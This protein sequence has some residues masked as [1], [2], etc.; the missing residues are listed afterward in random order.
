MKN[1]EKKF[2]KKLTKKLKEIP[3]K[4]WE[5][6]QEMFKQVY[7]TNIENFSIVLGEFPNPNEKNYRIIIKSKKTI[8]SYEAS[9]EI[10]EFYKNLIKREIIEEKEYEKNELKRFEELL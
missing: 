3:L 7:S 10:I 5:F 1:L 9:E 4:K 6:K 2:L 8:G